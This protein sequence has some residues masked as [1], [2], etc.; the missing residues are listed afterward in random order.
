M[1]VLKWTS[2]ASM[3]ELQVVIVEGASPCGRLDRRRPVPA[4]R[5]LQWKALFKKQ[6]ASQAQ[7]K[8]WWLLHLF[9][10]LGRPPSVRRAQAEIDA[11]AAS[12][13]E[14]LAV[15]GMDGF[16]PRLQQ[17]LEQWH[18]GGMRV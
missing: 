10:V 14:S 2:C 13:V 12:I 7:R 5:R 8:A 1:R 16:S 15:A 18:S 11:A 3:Q 9:K 4:G 17:R 6:W